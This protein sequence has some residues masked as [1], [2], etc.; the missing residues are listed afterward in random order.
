MVAFSF[1]QGR[2]DV[3]GIVPLA[4]QPVDELR[5]ELRVDYKAHYSAA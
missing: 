1:A 3:V 5:R 2:K 4:A